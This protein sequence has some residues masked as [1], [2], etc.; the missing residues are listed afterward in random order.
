MHKELLFSRRE[1]AFC[2]RWWLPFPETKSDPYLRRRRSRV[3]LERP[4]ESGHVLPEPSSPTQ[5]AD[6]MAHWL[7]FMSLELPMS[8]Q[9][10]TTM[11]SVVASDPQTMVTRAQIFKLAFSSVSCSPNRCI[12]SV[13]INAYG[14]GCQGSSTTARCLVALP[15][16]AV[17]GSNLLSPSVPE[18]A[19]HLFPRIWPKVWVKML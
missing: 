6:W 7:S 2:E 13:G 3:D 14:C 9:A 10:G 11:S 5:P 16:P 8:H 18:V 19:A 1:F 12:T 15:R 4:T 17:P